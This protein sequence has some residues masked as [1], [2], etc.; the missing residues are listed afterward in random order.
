MFQDL[1]STINQILNDPAMKPGLKE[2]FDA[3]VSFITPDKNL[4]LTGATVDLFLYEVK[5]NRELRD[6]TP[7]VEKNGDSFVRKEP[8]LR[9]DC[10][11]IVTTWSDPNA[12]G[13]AKVIEEHRLLAQA[14]L[15]LSRFPTIPEIY[16]QGSLKNQLY[17]PPTMVAQ[18]DPNK[19]AGDFWFALG[20][21]PRPAF[22][23]V[24]TIAM[25]LALTIEG[26]LVTTRFTNVEAGAGAEEE[27]WAQVGGRVATAGGVGIADALVDVLGAGLRARSDSDGRYSFVRVPLGAHNIRVVATGFQPKTQPLTVPGKPEDYDVT[28]IPLYTGAALSAGGSKLAFTPTN[29]APGV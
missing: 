26:P 7:I 29:Q 16:R 22:Y 10:S 15:W 21:P 8:P 23:L 13:E 18:M 6:P 14:L 2:L 3:N 1:D 9:V 12:T 19:N 24:V 27:Q 4:Q 28:L 25:D 20:I 5:E 11:Y 17:P